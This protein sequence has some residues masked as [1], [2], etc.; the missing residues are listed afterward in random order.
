MSLADFIEQMPK[1]ELHVH[2]EG[3]IQ[4]ETLLELA[5]RSQVQ[6]PAD[7][8]A[9]LRSWYKFTDFAHF[10][11]VYSLIS[12]CVR[13]PQDIE[14]IARQF[15]AGQ[16]AQ[17]IRF[18]EVTYTAY[19]LYHFNGIPFQDQL[20]AINRAR[21]WASAE[22]NTGMTLTIDIPRQIPA[23]E[24]PMIAEWAVSAMGNGV[25]AFGLGGPEIGN[26][27][28]KFQDAFDLAFKAGLPC[29]PHAGETVGPHSI[30]GALQHLHA[31][32]IGHGVRCL[33]DAR[34]VE[35]LRR[36]QIPLEICPTS[37]IALKVYP[38]MAHHPLP[39]L[40][41]QGLY[42]TLNSDDP[43]M[44]NTTL[45]NEYQVA[46]QT[47]NLTASDLEDLDLNALRASFLSPEQKAALEQD[48][49]AQ[50]ASLRAQYLD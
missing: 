39:M 24:G 13:T 40:L 9:G 25:S 14:L 1:V 19:S 41:S 45:T 37:N 48:F 47:F 5:R 7:S 12:S 30:W 28:E 49:Q 34:L 32:R 11:D 8:V 27:P 15:L 23:A 10:I 2:L 43:P 22:L 3:S 6:L 29:V 18:S 46:A 38:D 36:R 26:P 20:D 4:P 35:E 44:F 16:A 42:V 50:F 31:C 17:H 21:A 33:E